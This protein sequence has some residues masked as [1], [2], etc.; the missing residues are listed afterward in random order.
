[1]KRL[2]FFK[3]IR[4]A[5]VTINFRKKVKSRWKNR[6]QCLSMHCL[7]YFEWIVKKKFL[8]PWSDSDHGWRT[9]G[10]LIVFV[11]TFKLLWIDCFQLLTTIF[12]NCFGALSNNKLTFLSSSTTTSFAKKEKEFT[13]PPNLLLT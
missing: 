2:S 8:S 5:E 3:I 7:R 12:F 9:E 6:Y 13:V 1:M 10:Y 4:T 11:L